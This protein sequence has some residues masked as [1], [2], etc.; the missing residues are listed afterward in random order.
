L[1]DDEEVFMS[2]NKSLLFVKKTFLENDTRARFFCVGREEAEW[3]EHG[4][5]QCSIVDMEAT[6]LWL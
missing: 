1:K 3:T 4:G 2:N 5:C 6:D